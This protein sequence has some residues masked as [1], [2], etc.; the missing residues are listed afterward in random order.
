MNIAKNLKYFFILPALLS[1]L[2]LVALLA[3]GL[4]PGIDLAGGSLLQVSYPQGRPAVAQVEQVVAPLGLGEVRVQPSGADGYIL[5][6]RDLTND[7][8]NAFENKLSTLGHMQEDQYTSVGPTLGAELLRKGWIAL[9]LVTICIILFI[10]FA[11]RRVSKPVQSWKYGIVAIV[12]LLHDV[13]IPVG[14]FALL[15][16]LTGAEVGSLF[17]VALL[18][19]LGISIN[20]TIVVFDRIRE[21]LSLND[22]RNRREEFDQVVGRSIRQTLAR[23]INT[24]LTVVIV[25]AALYFVGPA[26]TKDFALTLI[27]GMVA[28]TYSSIF[29]ASPLLVAWEKWSRKRAVK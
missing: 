23:S 28:G 5:R 16:H 15:G 26:S 13:L 24:S 21:N 4:K 25:L 1:V 2:A 10:A 29:L 19:I 14:L 7:E 20:D 12:T 8:K 18:T 22:E 6:Q 11:F 17:I 3:W 9:A 27:V